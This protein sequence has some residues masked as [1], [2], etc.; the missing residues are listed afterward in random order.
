MLKGTE[1]P[2]DDDFLEMCEESFDIPEM[3]T[4]DSDIDALTLFADCQFDDPD[5]VAARKAEWEAL[6][7][8]VSA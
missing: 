8:G 1:M 5:A 4:E 6:F 3:N 2:E 7:D